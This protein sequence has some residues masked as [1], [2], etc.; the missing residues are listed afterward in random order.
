[1]K[2]IS[3]KELQIALQNCS[4]NEIS[5][6]KDRIVNH[7]ESVALATIKSYLGNNYDMNYE[8]RPYKEFQHSII[9]KDDERVRITNNETNH[10]FE[11]NWNIE[12][13][14]SDLYVQAST[15]GETEIDCF[16][17]QFDPLE[18]G[19][20]EVFL[21][22]TKNAC[23][24]KTLT[25]PIYSKIY[26]VENFKTIDNPNY[27]ESCGIINGSDGIYNNNSIY[28]IYNSEYVSG[29]GTNSIITL[30][31]N[32]ILLADIP[33]F[34]TVEYFD[35]YLL[36]NTDRDFKEDDRNVLLIQMILDI[37]IYTLIQRISPRQ[38]PEN[39]LK[40]YEDCLEQL[41]MIQRG[42]LVLG[43]KKHDNSLE[44]SN[45]MNVIWG[46]SRSGL[47]NTY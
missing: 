35:Q 9:Y 17:S 26:N 47:N 37:A 36:E 24:S 18:D 22:K 46:I 41:K 4:I 44:F 25:V 8:L 3:R 34:Q 40:R 12:L 7:S 10:T 32:N 42:D 1:M 2:F 13:I 43:L 38:I 6:F 28:N 29:D 30:N 19:D 16:Y 5:S 23:E 39:I 27:S 14:D 20:D 31:Y 11:T 33:N 45:N 21:V 15:A